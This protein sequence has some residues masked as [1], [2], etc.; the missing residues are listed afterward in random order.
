MSETIRTGLA[1]ADAYIGRFSQI[2][3]LAAPEALVA[4]TQ[5]Q[6]LSGCLIGDRQRQAH[7]FANALLNLLVGGF[8]QAFQGQA[9]RQVS[10]EVHHGFMRDG[11]FGLRG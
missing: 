4:H 8:S 2:L 6:L 9:T 10:P 1:K 7:D 3:C 11:V 5:G